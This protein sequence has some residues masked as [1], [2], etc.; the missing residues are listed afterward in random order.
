VPIN[1]YLIIIIG[2]IL[3]GH[4]KSF[5]NWRPAIDIKDTKNYFNKLADGTGINR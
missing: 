3:K 2:A 4:N 5:T 1:D